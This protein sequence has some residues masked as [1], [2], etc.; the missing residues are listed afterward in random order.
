LNKS[1]GLTDP[2]RE[3]QEEAPQLKAGPWAVV[4]TTFALAI[5]FALAVAYFVRNIDDIDTTAGVFVLQDFIDSTLD[6]VALGGAWSEGD[7]T[8]SNDENRVIEG[9]LI[10]IA[11]IGT[12][13]FIFDTCNY[14]RTGR[15]SRF[16]WAFRFGFE[17]FSQ[18][19]IYSFV[20]ASQAD[21]DRATWGMRLGIAQ[22]LLFVF[23]KLGELFFLLRDAERQERQAEQDAERQDAQQEMGAA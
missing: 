18:V 10:F 19:I 5:V 7:L 21:K 12:L 22:A 13:V 11:S 8:F 15:L 9:T 14:W 16:V 1:I 4:A 3:A 23:A 2:I 20:L 6:W 17:D